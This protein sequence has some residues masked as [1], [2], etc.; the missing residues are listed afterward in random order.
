MTRWS[1]RVGGWGAILLL[2]AACGAGDDDPSADAGGATVPTFEGM[3][4]LEIGEVEGEDAYLF[5]RIASV[6]ADPAG[7]ILV[8]DRGVSEVRVFDADGGFLFLFGGEGDGPEEFRGPC[9]LGFSPEGELWVRQEG[10]YTAFELGEAAV[11]YLRV[12]QRVFGGPLGGQ[13]GMGPVTFDAA[14]RLIDIGSL[15]VEADGRFTGGRVHLNADGTADTVVMR[16]PDAA[17]AGHET[18]VIDV[19]REG[20]SGIASLYLYQ[21]YGP[22]WLRAH[23]PG[24]A[25]ASASTS[26]YAVELHG[27]DGSAGEIIGPSL[28][29]PPLG[30]E[31]RE[32]ARGR[33]ERDMGRGNLDEPVFEIPDTKGPLASLFFDQAGRPWVEKEAAA[34]S[35]TVEADVY[36]GTTLVARYRWP[37]RVD[38]GAVPWAT[39]TTLYGTTTDELGVQRAARV[40]F[41]P[42]P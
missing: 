22:V 32:Y 30:A 4:D 33:L 38:P 23:G 20:F 35:E 7:R 34:G 16:E 12:Q 29:G 15:P 13:G 19:S 39:E 11:T 24:G 1:I 41:A 3:V 27:A 17:A 21:P 40:R 25:W 5:S 2:G 14:G 9:C 42:T 6:A 8:V 18:V 31:E 37:R 26:V 36:E 10:R 28:P